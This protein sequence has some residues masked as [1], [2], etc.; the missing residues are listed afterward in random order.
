MTGSTEAVGCSWVTM[1][2]TKTELTDRAAD[3]QEH[4]ALFLAVSIA[5]ELLGAIAF[6]A[7][8][9]I[10]AWLLVGSPLNS[11]QAESKRCPG[12]KSPLLGL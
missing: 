3:L 12:A 11:E 7:N 1:G 10:G 5:F 4:H 9:T 8:W 2:V 6:I